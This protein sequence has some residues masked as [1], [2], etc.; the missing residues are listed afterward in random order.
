MDYRGLNRI[1]KKNSTPIPITDEM[2][3]RLSSVMY[4]FKLDLKSGFHQIRV[5]KEDVEKTAFNTKYGQYEYLVMPM[6]LC[7]APQTFQTLMNN[8]FHDCIDNFIVIYLDDLLIFSSTMEEHLEHLETVLSRLKENELYASTKKCS[9]LQEEVE[10]LGLRVG[11][12]GVHIGRDRVEAIEE[13]PRP[14]SVTEI[15]SFIGLAQFFRRFVKGFSQ[16]TAPLTDLTRKG[17]G[18]HHWNADCDSAF[19]RLKKAL[20]IGLGI[21]P[22]TVSLL[23]RRIDI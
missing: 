18:I 3:D 19:A 9:F 16:I 4:F 5:R 11:R 15:R 8:V 17:S 2:F 12:D 21:P 13:W 23:F 1:T 6:G 14:T 22:E 20:T 10:F 7:D